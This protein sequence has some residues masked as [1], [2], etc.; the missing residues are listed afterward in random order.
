MKWITIGCGALLSAALAAPGAVLAAPLY[1]LTV[2][3]GAGSVAKDIN[4][5]G[6]LVGY[7][8]N[9]A[10]FHAF[11]YDGT[12]V[13]DLSPVVGAGSVAQRLND[14]GTIVGQVYSDGFRSGF[15][16][17]GGASIALPLSGYSEANGL[18]N[19][20]AIV[21]ATY[22][23]L[24]GE[25]CA[26]SAYTYNGGMFTNL[27]TTADG[28]GSYA[29]AIN[30]AGH[31]AG[32]NILDVATN[33]EEPFFY[34][35]GVMQNLGSFGAP[36]G[37]S[38]AINNHD[39]VV[40]EIG[41]AYVDSDNESPYPRHAFLYDGGVVTDL[42]ALR[43]GGDSSAHDINDRGQI[44][45]T[46]DTDQGRLAFLYAAGSMVL[47]DS[48]IDPCLGWTVEGADGINDLGQIAATACKAG[49]CYAVRLDLA[50]A[51]PEPAEGLLLA[52]GLL[53]LLFGRRFM[54]VPL[55]SQVR[56]AQLT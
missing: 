23:P 15:A 5:S 48:L 34:S 4:A 12:T 2:I 3:G 36:Y 54:T 16:Y 46:T 25:C 35:D 1:N 47:L 53:A 8:N 42:G 14:S 7:Q 55:A 28:Y 37:H 51:V 22:L 52:V 50:S 31:V 17:A 18:N 43:Y 29:A 26:L 24:N 45:G 32:T 30:D 44:V 6:Q 19:A 21:G 38:L 27:G 41:A 39:Q 13:T 40:G 11:F 9:G 33:N 56:C 20:G 10:D 49:L